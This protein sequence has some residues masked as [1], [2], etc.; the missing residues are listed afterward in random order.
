MGVRVDK[1]NKLLLLPGRQSIPVYQSH[2]WPELQIGGYKGKSCWRPE[3]GHVVIEGENYD[4]ITDHVA[5]TKFKF[6]A[7]KL[8][9]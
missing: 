7:S 9:K 4:Y 5:G 3:V 6:S 2:V 1:E 8:Q